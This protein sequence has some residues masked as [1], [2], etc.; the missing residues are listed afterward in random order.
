M[1]VIR[2]KK[3]GEKRFVAKLWELHKA[4]NLYDKRN[5]GWFE[6][7]IT[8]WDEAKYL[9]WFFLM[10]NDN[11]VAF[12]TIQRFYPGAY[13][14]LTRLYITREYRRFT[15]PKDD[16]FYSPS[17]RL[18]TTQLEFIEQS[19][20]L[21]VSLQGT[22][23]MNAANRYV[24]KLIKTT[25]LKWQLD[26]NMRLTCPDAENKECWQNIIYTGEEPKMW[27]ITRDDWNIQYG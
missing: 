18:L 1:K 19:R 10:D 25:D 17:M 2:L 21:F 7:L 13:R 26:P 24:K 4:E 9:D 27:A 5:H 12:S 3:F 8:T 6:Y 22:S 23:R 16:K 20:T 11:L 15:V 14:V